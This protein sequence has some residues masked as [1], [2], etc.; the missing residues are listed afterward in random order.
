MKSQM[1]RIL[2]TSQTDI[3]NIDQ[4]VPLEHLYMQRGLPSLA[5][6]IFQNVELV[7][8]DAS[9]FVLKKKDDTPELELIKGKLQAQGIKPIKTPITEEAIQDLEA[10]YGEK[11]A[12]DYIT[13]MLKGM[14]NAEEN[15]ICV[16]FLQDNAVQA[17]SIVLSSPGV[18]ETSLFEI[19]NKVTELILKMNTKNLRTLCGYC[20]LPFNKL[21]SIIAAS[22]YSGSNEI[23]TNDAISELQVSTFGPIKFYMNPDVTDEN[24]YVGLRSPTRPD[25]TSAYYGKYQNE[26]VTTTNPNTGGKNYIIYD[27]FAL[28]M[29]PLHTQENPMLMKF[30]FE[31][32]LH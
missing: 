18:S 28:T 31:D 16:K 3:A 1:D 15:K 32:G 13:K 23:E 29:S 4:K 5:E 2:E 6:S 30:R 21:S 14:A 12:K 7:T 8:P 17:D 10:M 9:V 20:V 27:R 25:C 22:I 24:C 11:A 19:T 26:I